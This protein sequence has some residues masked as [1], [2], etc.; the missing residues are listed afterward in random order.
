MTTINRQST[1]F[2]FYKEDILKEFLN[3]K[4]CYTK[5]LY[6]LKSIKR[7]HKKDWTDF[8]SFLKNF[9]CPDD[10]SIYYWDFNYIK[11]RHA[12]ECVSIQ[13][14]SVDEKFVA[15]VA[16]KNPERVIK[17][18]FLKDRVYYTPDELMD[19]INK[20]IEYREKSIKEYEESIKNFD[21]TC[22][23]LWDK[24]GELLEFISSIDKNAYDFKK[25]AAKTIEHF[26]Q[27]K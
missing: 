7:V 21:K 3:W 12:W 23:E 19:E 4:E 25:I 17:E 13:E 15:N 14:Y 11:I 26:T 24:M 9:S 27:Y 20:L 2:D 18:S 22:D 16:S 8:Q 10:V 5:E 1:H 6:A